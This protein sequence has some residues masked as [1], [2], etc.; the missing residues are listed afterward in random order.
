MEYGKTPSKLQK[1]SL[2]SKK[3][4]V[5]LSVDSSFQ[6]ASMGADVFTQLCRDA[7][8]VAQLHKPP[9]YW[10]IVA[11]P[12][13]PRRNIS[14]LQLI[15]V[16][17]R[18]IRDVP[19]F[20]CCIRRVSWPKT[21]LHPPT[22]S[23]RAHPLESNITTTSG[24][25]NC[26]HSSTCGK[27]IM[28]FVFLTTF[29]WVLWSYKM[30]LRWTQSVGWMAFCLRALRLQWSWSKCHLL[31]VSQSFQTLMQ[32]YLA[33]PRDARA[34]NRVTTNTESWMFSVLDLIKLID[35]H[36]FRGKNALNPW[37]K[38]FL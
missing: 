3:F 30:P 1:W 37:V 9:A 38:Y 20:L 23:L 36:S 5:F 6:L 26:M 11:Q 2:K 32:E 31:M 15:S 8:A 24:F 4:T 19:L 27:Q 12:P 28:I 16:C 18:I 10:L 17:S 21:L 29:L 33:T 35:A 14:G 34:K 7:D 25:W 13:P 22:L